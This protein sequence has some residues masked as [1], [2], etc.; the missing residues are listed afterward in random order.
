MPF[1]R[2]NK[3]FLGKKH[4]EEAKKKMRTNRLYRKFSKEHRRNLSQAL[5]GRIFSTLWRN[6]LSEKGKLR[7][8]DKSPNWKGGISPLTKLIIQTPKY[9][10]WH[11][12]IL[13]RDNFTCIICNKRGGKL[14]V[15]HYP[16][17]FSVIFHK[18]NIENLQE[19][20]NCFEF[21]DIGNGRTLCYECHHGK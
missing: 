15:D 10:L 2:G 11:S 17:S 8:A 4:T 12:A 16:N 1:Q 18:N 7:K 13:I 14:E 20:E 6:K 5:K 19:A 21:W 9:Q 3:L